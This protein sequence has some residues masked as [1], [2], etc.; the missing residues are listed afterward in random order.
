MINP[1]MDKDFLSLLSR[2]TGGK[3]FY[4][5]NFNQ[6]FNLLEENNRRHSKEKVSLSEI[7]L[8]SN[9]WMLISIIVLFAV[10]WFLRKRSG[11]L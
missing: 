8:W 4:G 7:T 9:E 3:F 6:L 1:G 11:M 5:K 10:E 2:Q